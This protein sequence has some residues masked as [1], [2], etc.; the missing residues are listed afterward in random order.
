MENGTVIDSAQG[1]ATNKKPTGWEGD[2][3]NEPTPS[4]E[5]Q[6]E[7]GVMENGMVT[8]SGQGRASCNR[9]SDDDTHASGELKPLVEKN[10]QYKLDPIREESQLD[11]VV[12]EDWE[13]ID[14]KFIETKACKSVESLIQKENLVIVVGHSGSGKS[15]TIQHIALKYR[16]KGWVVKK[17]YEVKDAI[18]AFI[19]NNVLEKQ[20]LFV[21][22]DPIGTESFDEQEYKS[23]KK[24][25]EDLKACSKKCKLLLSCRKCVQS[26]ERAMGLFKNRSIIVDIDAED[27]KLSDDEKLKIWNKHKSDNT[28]IKIDLTEIIKIDAYFPLLCKL[29]F[30]DE[31]NQKK[32]LQFF[33]KPVKVYKDEI[34]YYKTS[35]KDKFCALVLLVLFNNELCVSDLQNEGNSE[36]MYK[37]ALKLCG[38]EDCTAPST[39]RGALETLHGSY[40]TK[41][42]G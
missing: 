38:M 8:D 4:N 13:D 21:L 28:S 27:S 34:E 24:L 40:V 25:E 17:A 33:K 18:D 22:H 12:F 41:K 39:I 26:D 11:Q 14:S 3:Y 1:P 16:S 23:W 7:T 30:S 15:A 2:K 36:Q 10:D 20:T 37:L 19:S 6:D 42:R 31:E 9:S 32:G 5:R 35:S 29:F